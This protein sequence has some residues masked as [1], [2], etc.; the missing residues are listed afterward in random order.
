M[1]SNESM[2]P[3]EIS[4]PIEEYRQLMNYKLFVDSWN[5]KYA[6]CPICGHFHPIGEKCKIDGAE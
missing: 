5:I 4:L 1:S 6:V 3:V 2:E